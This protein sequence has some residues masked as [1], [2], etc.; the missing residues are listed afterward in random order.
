MSLAE[1]DF[2]H[3]ADGC[4]MCLEPQGKY[5]ALA[6]KKLSELPSIAQKRVSLRDTEDFH[7]V[8]K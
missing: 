4:G 2:A 8:I 1:Y 6:L 3:G 7:R 5:L